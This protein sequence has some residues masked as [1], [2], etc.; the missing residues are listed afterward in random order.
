ML[1]RS[2]REIVWISIRWRQTISK[3][4]RNAYDFSMEYKKVNIGYRRSSFISY[5]HPTPQQFDTNLM[6]S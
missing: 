4:K 3:G 6:N 5:H 2:N 1:V